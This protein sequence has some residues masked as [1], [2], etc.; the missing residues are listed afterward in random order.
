MRTIRFL[1]LSATLTA[2]AF[3]QEPDQVTLSNKDVL[4]G[5]VKAMADGKLVITSPVLGDVTVPMANVEQIVT[6]EPIQVR[7]KADT[8]AS[9]RILGIEGGALKLDGEVPSVALDNLAMINP[10][11][12]PA[13]A[14]TGT[15]KVTGLYATGN[16]DRR[17]MGLALDAV[18][19]SDV[20]RITFD[21]SWDYAEDKKDPDNDPSTS[22][23]KEWDLT[24]RRTGGGL[25]YDYFLTKRW[26]ALVT[27][28]VLGDTLANLDLR[29]TG[30]AGL[31]YS[32]IDNDDTT[33]LAEA[34]L[35]YFNE[36]YRIVAD[37]DP[38]SSEYLAA[39]VAYTLRH[40]LSD[41]TKLLHSCEAFPSTEDATDVYLQAKTEVT[42]NLT[43][44]MIASVAWV[45][46]YDN[47]PSPG[48]ER[49][50]HRVLLSVG[51]SF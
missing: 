22:N 2:S 21:A 11:V 42:T 39:R 14:W 9:G 20:D 43:D 3:A 7:T 37:G 16:T 33:L 48:F 27:T 12:A 29:F 26:Y 6:K 36:N 4:T 45:M 25:K 18:R 1:T 38:D 10:P 47:T 13:P 5:K 30:G 34:G 23:I 49:V 46:D 31:G 44:N 41:R 17:A 32:V 28:R 51:W 15:L 24:Q 40:N 8:T 50:D 19:R 35:S